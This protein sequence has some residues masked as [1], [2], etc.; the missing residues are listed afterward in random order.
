MKIDMI[1]VAGFRGFRDF[2]RIPFGSSFTVIEGANG[3][4]KST[5]CDALEFCLTGELTKYVVEKAANEKV[6]DYLWWRGE[7]KPK[8]HFVR[9]HFKDRD[10]EPFVVTRTRDGCDKSLD[11]IRSRFCLD[12]VPADALRILVETTIIRDESIAAL[13]LD[14]SDVER[15]GRVQRAL[16]AVATEPLTLRAARVAKAVDAVHR[17]SEQSLETL[18]RE[19]GALVTQRAEAQSQLSRSDQVQLATAALKSEFGI[20]ELDATALLAQ[21]R[22]RLMN[23]RGRLDAIQVAAD[24]G[25]RLAAE[26]AEVDSTAF[27]IELTSMRERSTALEN[28]VH[29]AEGIYAD[30]QRRLL[31][32][33]EAD[34]WTAAWS[35]LLAH[36]NELGL[37]KGHC[38]LCDAV[39]TEGEFSAAI[40]A[41]RHRLSGRGEATVE[42]QAL[43]EVARRDHAQLLQ[44]LNVARL[45]LTTLEGRAAAATTI[46]QELDS[47]A[48]R[49]SLLVGQVADPAAMTE[50]INQERSVLI[51]LD[52]HV[53]ALASSSE[54]TR[55]TELEAS[56]LALQVQAE[57]AASANARSRKASEAAKAIDHAIKR[58]AAD[59]VDERLAAISP[60]LSELFLRL[61]PHMDWRNIQ[62]RIRGDV[63]KFLSLAVGDD[64]NPQFVFSSGQRRVTGLAFLLSVYLARQWCQWQSLVLDDPVQ[65]I[66]DYRALNLVELLSSIRMD[67]KQIVCAV[68]DGALADLLCRRLRPTFDEP[69]YRIVVEQGPG[70]TSRIANVEPVSSAARRVLDGFGPTRASA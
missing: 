27:Q 9:V 29:V 55:I 56:I 69:G 51:R 48:N 32:E 22:E 70:G 15:Y 10:G 41:A 2:A 52:Q 45:D 12:E 13:S 23:R 47:L 50:L 20:S 65:H 26:L 66:D 46:R 31:L 58:T 61:R 11:E 43:A 16:G 3:A 4:G 28:L 5:I 40:N 19:V 24:R 18:K 67:G 14:L 54:F 34:A 63:R 25:R 36:G 35:S 57:R 21:G 1:E 8:E 59:M 44:Q 6:S 64:L 62:Y 37:Q 39:R 33:R 7:S 49:L 17:Q 42:A 60:L 68:E 30:S 53:R 38:P